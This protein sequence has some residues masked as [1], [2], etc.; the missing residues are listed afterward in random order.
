M[1]RNYLKV[2]WRSLLYNKIQTLINV[3]GLATGLAC[4]I[5]IYLW[6]ANEYHIDSAQPSNLYRVYERRLVDHKLEGSYD[7]PGVLADALK[8]GMPEVQYA[9]TMAFGET[10]TFQVGEQVLKEQG[11]SAGADYFKMFNRPLLEGNAGSAL[12]SPVAIAISRKMAVDFFGSP[13]KAIGN[14]IRYE[15]STDF[16]VT[17][18]F[19]DLPASE[20]QHFDFLTNWEVFQARNT[21]TREWG[22]QGPPTFI[23]LRPDANPE[24]VN[25]KIARFMDQY[26]HVDRK[27][28][29]Y[30]IDLAI[31]PFRESYLHGNLQGGKASGGRI[32]EVRLFGVVAVFI[33]LMACINFMNLSTA[34][35]MKRAREI[36]VRKA[37]GA[38]RTSLITQFIIESVLVTFLAVSAALVIVLLLMPYFNQLTGKQLTLPFYSPAF[39]AGVAGLTLFTGL[40]AGSYPALVL[41]GFNPIRVLKGSLSATPGGAGLRKALVI[42]QFTMSVVL[43]IATILVSRQI[44]F[45][46]SQNLGYEKANLVYSPLEGDLG[47]QYHA[48]RNEALALPGIE[49]I[50]HINK[51][52]VNIYGSSAAVYWI[53]KDTTQNIFFTNLSVG[54]DYLK[55]MKIKLVAGRE[56]S[57]DYPSDTSA[58]ILN[59]TAA[60]VTGYKDPIGQPFTMFGRRGKIVGV[61][62]DFH[63]HSLHE[64]ISPMV[65]TAGENEQSGVLVVRISPGK[66]KVAL[67]SLNRLARRFNPAF[68]P[69]FYFVD[70]EYQKLYAGEQVI[71]KL[72]DVFA[73]LAIFISCLGLLGLAMFTAEQRTKELGIRKVLGASVGSLFSLLSVQFL[74]LIIIAL[75][76]ATPLAWVGIHSWLQGYA[77]RTPMQWW[78]FLLADGG[79]IFIALATVSVQAI[80][81]ALVNPVKSL[82]A[83]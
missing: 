54:Y 74:R 13:K 25:E 1:I 76:I 69:V 80:K 33:L 18:V 42:F 6:I 83:E 41:S 51:Q 72:A 36:G 82:K 40:L 37:V 12:N 21:W 59:E 31:Q 77:Y 29:T 73:V 22:N 3:A 23:M 7:T 67:S 79:V 55:T 65:I 10:S 61:V 17:A 48:F 24:A 11:N 63:F 70:E 30:I 81:A 43:I 71:G 66:T 9:T 5:F 68:P 34:R 47:K 57:H 62:K 49:A 16:K 64:E 53:N 35:S 58:Y 27:T 75:L 8:R 20:S 32:E 15:N 46:R 56:F 19:E 44:D 2:A 45:I 28:S 4:S 50:T 14:T 38:L 52:P 39:L 78:L 26:S 60:R